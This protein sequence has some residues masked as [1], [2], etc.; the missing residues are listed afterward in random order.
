MENLLHLLLKNGMLKAASFLFENFDLNHL[1]FKQ[2][3][4]GDIPIT[5]AIQN[6]QP[7]L[8][9]KELTLIKLAIDQL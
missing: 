7:S 6:I 9:Q 3:I 1:Y 5:L 2:N 8:E 4:A